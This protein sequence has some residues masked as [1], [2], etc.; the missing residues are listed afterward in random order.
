MKTSALTPWLAAFLAGELALASAARALERLEPAEGCYLGVSLGP[1]DTSDRFSARL[2]L[3]PAVHAEF[4]EFPLTAGSR[5]NLMKFLDQVRP[6]K[7]IALITLEPYAGLSNVTEE[8]SLDF[9]RLCQNQ[10]TQGIGGILVRFAHEMNGNWNPWGQQPILYK[11]KFRLVAQHI[12]AN[13]TRTAMLWGPSYGGGYPYGTQSVTPGSPDFA[14]L[15]TDSDGVLT[16]NDDMYEPYYPGD[17]AVDWVGLTLYHWGVQWPWIENELPETNSFANLLTGNYLGGNGDEMAVPDFYARYC[18][19]G[20]HNKPLSIPETAAFFNP[21]QGGAT[22]FAIKEAW[23]RQLFNISGDTPEA[24][25]VALHFPKLKCVCWFDRYKLEPEQRQWIDWRI[26]AYGPV[27]SAFVRHAR[28]LHNG[29]PWFLTAQEF[30]GLQRPDCIAE[31]SLPSSLPLAGHI[32]LSLFVKT[33]TNCDLVVDLLDQNRQRQAGTRLP[34]TAG[35]RAVAFSITINQPLLES[36]IYSWNIYL[37]P[38]SGDDRQAFASYDG[39]PAVA[40]AITPSI[41]ILASPPLLVTPSNFVARVKY[42]AA[43]SA[44]AVVNLLDEGYNWRGGGTVNVSRGD[45]LIEV[46][47]LLQG[48]VTDGNYILES[49]LSDSSTNW[50]SPFARSPNCPLRVTPQVRQDFINAIV[51]PATVPAGEVFRFVI[52]YAALTNRELHVDLFDANTNFL[53]G[54]LQPVPAGAGI[55]D[56]TISYPGAVPG[57]YFATAFIT[58]TGQS[59]T[60]AVAWSADQRITVVASDYQQWIDSYWGVVLGNDPVNPRDDPDGDGA[61]NAEEFI[62]RTNPRDAASVLNAAIGTSEAGLTVRWHS[63]AGSRYQVVECSSLKGDVW[64]PFGAPVAGT[65]AVLEAP[66]G[67]GGSARF[68]RVQALP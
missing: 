45:G 36:A 28:T 67:A 22:E 3:R 23:F 26:S 9:A 39:S 33:R 4:F 30:D 43:E 64:T 56:L 57:E 27:R 66:V 55:H 21:H 25:D 47:V 12:H 37:T 44:V 50:Q 17:D 18:A 24:L 5:S 58:P 41:R 65:G 46:P 53:A 1:G 40:R 61:S 19:D 29:R 52:A 35:N 48:G 59:W 7:S 60:G 62:A 54:N 68:F 31:E 32:A 14:A 49:F 15:D 6:T 34:L 10:E 38:T 2:G 16:Q 11:E 63:V 20:V 42:T 13:T 51:D 8:A